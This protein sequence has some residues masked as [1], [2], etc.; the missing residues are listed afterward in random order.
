M[1]LNEIHS[2]IAPSVS[3]IKKPAEK[4][5]VKFGKLIFSYK[6]ALYNFSE[7]LNQ[8]NRNHTK[9]ITNRQAT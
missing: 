4:E 6:F 3:L 8:W 1:S 2:V 7:I 5:R 9:Q